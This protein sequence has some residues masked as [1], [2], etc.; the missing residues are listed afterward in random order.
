[1]AGDVV[2]ETPSAIFAT[3]TNSRMF[4]RYTGIKM[5]ALQFLSPEWHAKI[6]LLRQLYESNHFKDGA[7]SVEK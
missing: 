4:I 2:F 1:M 7:N 3:P 5:L 6:A